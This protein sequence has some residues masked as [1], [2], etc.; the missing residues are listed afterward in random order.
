[1]SSPLLLPLSSLPA[2]PN[3]H[4]RHDHSVEQFHQHLI[5]GSGGRAGGVKRSPWV[6]FVHIVT[7]DQGFIQ[8]GALVAVNIEQLSRLLTHLLH[9]HWRLS[10]RIQLPEPLRLGHQSTVD[11]FI[12]NTFRIQAQHSPL[13]IGTEPAR[14]VRLGY[15]A[16]EL[17]SC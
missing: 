7:L 17:T 13:G 9:Q 14:L 4:L 5:L 12:V 6:C 11:H 10:N 3:L 16:I 8:C 2:K 15:Q 1:M